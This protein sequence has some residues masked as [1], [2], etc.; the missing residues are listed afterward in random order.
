VA[1][2][3]LELLSTLHQFN[4]PAGVQVVVDMDI[5]LQA[6]MLLLLA[7]RDIM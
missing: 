2:A 3:V 7:V 4:Q 6:L 5:I 1:A